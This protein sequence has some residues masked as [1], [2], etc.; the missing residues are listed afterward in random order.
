MKTIV[1]RLVRDEKGA[2]LVMVLILL[3]I[4]GLIIGPLLSYMGTG[5]ITGQV[6]EMRTNELYAADAGVED[7]IWS[8]GHQSIP[9]G[10]WQESDDQPGW[11]MYEY[12]EPLI[13]NGKSVDVTV[14]RKDLDPTCGQELIYRILA[15]AVTD[16]GGGTAALTGTQ[17]D[18]YITGESSDY[19]GILDNVIT[20]QNE[21]AYPPLQQLDINYPEGHGP[22]ANYDGLWPTPEELAEFYWED[23][24]DATHYDGDTEIDLEGNSCPPG[25]I[26]IN[27][28]ENNSWP[29]GLGPLSINGTLDI[30]NSSNAPA[31]LTLTGTI[32]ITG[33]T[34]I[35][36]NKEMTLDLNGQTIF[37]A[38]NSSDPQ[39]ALWI[40]GKCTIIGP[41]C[42]IAV[43]DV[44]FEPNIPVGMTDPI[45]IMSVSGETTLQPGGDFYGAIAGSVEVDLQPGT[46]LNYPE[47]GFEDLINFPGFVEPKQLVYSIYSWEVIPLWRE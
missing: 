43:G 7:A 12:P 4:S 1:K 15:T 44:Y 29:S 18:A 22:V 26:Y 37:V 35:K 19:S 21:I 14:Y 10:L 6:Y 16:D 41:G 36:P 3:L 17:I 5:L 33:D 39:K 42:I 46:S 45:F 40:G 2:S 9:P 23:V 13:V 24:K 8:I 47:A 31:T 20:S 32:Y 11:W 25:P 27:D 38:S 34:L 30:K 28:E